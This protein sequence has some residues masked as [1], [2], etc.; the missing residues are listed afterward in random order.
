MTKVEREE[1][2][3]EKTGSCKKVFIPRGYCTVYLEGQAKD[4][5]IDNI[6]VSNLGDDVCIENISDD[7]LCQKPTKANTLISKKGKEK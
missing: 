6:Q 3:V 7:L 4:N 1:F 5:K 2:R